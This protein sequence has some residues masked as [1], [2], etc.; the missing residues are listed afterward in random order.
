[1]FSPVQGTGKRPVRARG[2]STLSGKPPVQ[3]RP[4]ARLLWCIIIGPPDRS[5][6]AIRI[7]P[8]G[9]SD[10]DG[11]LRPVADVELGSASLC[12]HS[13]PREQPGSNAC[14]PVLQLDHVE[15][16]LGRAAFR[17]NPVVRNVGPSCARRQPFI[18]VAFF[19]V[20]DVA[21]GPALPGFVGLGPHRDFPSCMERCLPDRVLADSGAV[22]SYLIGWMP[23]PPNGHFWL[24]YRRTTG[25]DT[26]DADSTRRNRQT[27]SAWYADQDWLATIAAHVIALG[28]SS[29][30]SPL[31]A[32]RDLR[33]IFVPK[34]RANRVK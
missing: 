12:W 11:G 2:R 19:L 26:L 27:T 3:L 4:L 31:A 20:I 8:V 16:A 23:S 28:R 30:M 9:L 7:T 1:M 24:P 22:R 25:W 14:P 34:C 5:Y 32:T 29:M 15:F 10:R 17:T 21:A 33:M 18:R 13:T 6:R